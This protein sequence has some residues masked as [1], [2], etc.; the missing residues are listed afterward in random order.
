M[1]NGQIIINKPETVKPILLRKSTL[2][3][4]YKENTFD[5]CQH[6]IECS[7]TLGWSEIHPLIMRPIILQIPT[8]DRR[9]DAFSFGIPMLTACASMQNIISR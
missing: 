5:C 8:I 1:Q 2:T 7:I 6:K 9:N 3:C 4:K